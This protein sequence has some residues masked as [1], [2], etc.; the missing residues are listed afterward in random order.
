MDEDYL[1][2]TKM[3]R[4]R[5]LQVFYTRKTF[6]MSFK[7]GRDDTFVDWKR[8]CVTK[9]NA[10]RGNGRLLRRIHNNYTSTH[11]LSRNI[12]RAWYTREESFEREKYVPLDRQSELRLF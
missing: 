2:S 4:A 3:W 11:F 10:R 12:F 8:N 1:I 6:G 9:P 7:R 5:I